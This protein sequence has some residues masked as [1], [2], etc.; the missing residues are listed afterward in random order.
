MSTDVYQRI[1]AW[2]TEQQIEFKALHHEPTRTS[3]AA[4]AA[5]GEDVRIGGK[6]ILMKI[7]KTF[8]LLVL[9][10]AL[11]VDSRKVKDYFGTRRTRFATPD[12]LSEL[13]GVIPGAVPPFGSPINDLELYVDESILANDRIAF[14]AGSLTDSIIMSTK[15]YLELVKPK[16]IQ[17]SKS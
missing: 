17:F 5:R 6:A 4:A 2:L 10:A 1:T 13:T 8:R 11:K 9:S 12:E 15:D 3:E 14:N 16:V 7:N